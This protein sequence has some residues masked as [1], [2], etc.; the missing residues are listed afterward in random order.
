MYETKKRVSEAKLR[1]AHMIE[2]KEKR[3][4]RCL[5]ALCVIF[6]CLLVGAIAELSGGTGKEALVQGMNGA[7]LLSESTGGYVFVA[8]VSFIAAACLTLICIKIREKSTCFGH[9]K[10]EN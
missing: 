8:V 1:A 3:A 7:T 9:G 5:S 10:K 6:S 4:I 2:K